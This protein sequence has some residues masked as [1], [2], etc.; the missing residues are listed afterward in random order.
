MKTLLRGVW[1]AACLAVVASPA[2]A[3]DTKV[4]WKDV[5]G[6]LQANNPVGAGTGQILGGTQPWSTS[7]GSAE[8]NLTTGD[9]RFRVSGL[10]FAGGNFLGTPGTITEVKGTLVCDTD[11]SAGGGNST[12][13]DTPLVPLGAQGD[14]QFSGNVGALPAACLEPDLAFVIRVGA[15]R[16]I[17]N[18]AVREP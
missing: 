5:I 13:V 2:L 18:G 15:G 14:A 11:G 12:L 3:A 9:V 6:I 4:R 7:R 8:V 16:W 17:A 10:V 1:I